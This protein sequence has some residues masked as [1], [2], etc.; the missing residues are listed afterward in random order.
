MW[1]ISGSSTR[2]GRAVA[3]SDGQLFVGSPYKEISNV[4]QAGLVY[5]YKKL[6]NDAPVGDNTHLFLPIMHK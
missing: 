1:T 5:L 3:L 2:Y 4:P 6:D